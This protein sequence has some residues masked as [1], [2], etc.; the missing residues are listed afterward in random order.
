M[1]APETVFSLAPVETDKTSETN[2]VSNSAFL[3]AVFGDDLTDEHPIVVSFTGSPTGAPSKVWTGT[4]WSSDEHVAAALPTGANNY[5]SLASFRPNEAGQYRRQKAFFH[6]LHAVMLDDVGS[7]VDMERLT[8]P[9]SWLLETSPGNYQA[10][11]LL[12]TPLDDGPA[13]DRLMKA[14]V[15]AGLCDPGS[16]GP[17]TRLARL[18]IAVNGKHSPPFVCRM[19]NW[20]PT[21]RYTVE[22][23]VTGLQLEMASAER[24]TRQGAR[25]AQESPS[26]GDP[27]WIPRPD[28][29]A[30]LVELKAHG[31]YK[32]PLGG[33]KH[34]VTCPWVSEHT[35]QADGG[36]AYFEPDDHW[37][38]GGFKCQ[39]GH[40]TG[41]HIRELLQHLGVAP[42]AAR[43]KPTIYVVPGEISRIVDAAERELAQTGFHYQ[44][45]GLIVT[46]VTD[47]GTRETRVQEITQPALLRAL[48][49][50]ATWERF[51]ER[52]KDWARTDPP[53]RHV[54]VLFDAASYPH[55]PVLNGLARQPY[56]R[57]DG[58]L[59][60][61]AGYDQTTGMFGVFNAGE[62][63]VPK[64]PVREQAETALDLLKDLLVEF[65]F[66]SESDLAG[67]LAAMLTATL[68]P[69]LGLAPMFHVRAHM[70]GSGKSYL[71]ELITAFATP[72]RG[73]PTGFPADD[74][75]CR[76][77][78]LAELLRAP[79]VIE[80]DNLTSD[81]VAHKSLCT[82]LTSEFLSGRILGVSK[83]ATVNTRTLL[84]SSGNNVGPVQDMTRRCITINLNP[85]CETP[86][87]RRFT[88]PDLVRDVLRERSRYVSAALTIVRAWI[89]AGK[90]NTTCNSLASYGDWSDVCRQPLLWLGCADPTTSVFDAMKEDPD[91]ET[92]DRLMAAWF[93]VFDRK[94]AMVR[95]AVME[96]SRQ[97]PDCIELHEVLHDIASER[98]EINRRRLGWWLKRHAGRIVNGRRLIRAS[99]ARSAEAWVVEVLPESV[100]SVSQVSARPTAQSVSAYASASRGE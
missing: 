40:C 23:L 3:R 68:R 52:S 2:S 72:Q 39:H 16:N 90:P 20:Y 64:H 41:R 12:D 71:C 11:Y 87:A 27:V 32:R 30:V 83:T 43:M 94:P 47:P 86:A 56:L 1:N 79:A 82:A 44:R 5:F 76:K 95:D 21:Q 91:R 49:G 13:A 99:G 73:T 69:S 84:L 75:E 53:A 14:I 97:Q 66:G 96:A 70:V 81:L 4:P 15:E 37:P 28:K 25:P 60:V 6:A 85:G 26:D 19:Q 33:G 80:F 62:F 78:L 10:G 9:P 46:V 57:P 65:S 34:D 36:T 17:R 89:I 100:S 51:D 29:N 61:E 45:G 77:L 59:M 92:L 24:H 63:S 48:S 8:L 67:A 22:A 18:P 38:I 42:S 35:D 7:K 88:R 55:L 31:L 98:G 74:E 54:G 58:S 50:S 93:S